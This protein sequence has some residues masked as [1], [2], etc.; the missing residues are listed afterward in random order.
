MNFI[1]A[2]LKWIVDQI[3]DPKSTKVNNFIVEQIKL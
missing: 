2:K 1:D 3:I